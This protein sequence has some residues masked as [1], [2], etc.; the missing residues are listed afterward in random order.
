MSSK[1]YVCTNPDKSVV[2]AIKYTCKL[3]QNDLNTSVWS[4]SEKITTFNYTGGKT[5]QNKT[6]K[7]KKKHTHTP[8][9]PHTP[10]THTPTHTQ[11]HSLQVAQMSGVTL[12]L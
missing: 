11:K 5:K 12:I 7:K 10:H 9:P 1:N 6:K 3:Y 2:I 8:P 4:V